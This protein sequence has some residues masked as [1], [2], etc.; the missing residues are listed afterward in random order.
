MAEARVVKFCYKVSHTKYQTWDDKLSLKKAW[1][2][3]CDFYRATPC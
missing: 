2:G 3:I 1:A